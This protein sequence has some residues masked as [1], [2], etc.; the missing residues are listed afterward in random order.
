MNRERGASSLAL[1]LLLLLLGSLLL[2]GADQQQE[3]FAARV[4]T[5]SQA[6]QRQAVVNSAMEWGKMQTWQV[7]SEKQCR[8][9]G[10]EN[11]PVCLRVLADNRILLIV[12]Y[13]GTSVWRQGEQQGD[14]IVFSAH[15]WSDYCPLREA[16]LCQLP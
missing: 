4:A 8:F 13:Q 15:G 2:Q 5:E 6:L 11:V 1:V 10:T 7:H 16:V 3:S 14:A 12:N 9:Y